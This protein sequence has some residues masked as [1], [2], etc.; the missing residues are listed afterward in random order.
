MSEENSLILN[1]VRILSPEDAQPTAFQDTPSQIVSRKVY[2]DQVKKRMKTLDARKQSAW[3]LGQ[4]TIRLKE[5]DVWE[6]YTIDIRSIP[7]GIMESIAKEYNSAVS[8]FPMKWNEETKTY[9]QDF[10][11]PDAV[12]LRANLIPVQNRLAMD[13]VLYG[14][15]TEIKDENGNVVWDA[16]RGITQDKDSAIATI[17]A[18]GLTWDDIRIIAND[19]DDLMARIDKEDEESIEK[20]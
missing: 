20:K 8:S 15:M 17:W 6:T 13:K 11:S 16:G 19:I 12:E 5:E 9:D 4:S 1:D 2:G 3:R 10:W 14:M 18:M 7:G